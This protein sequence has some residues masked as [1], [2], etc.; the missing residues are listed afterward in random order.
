[1]RD[2]M[3]DLETLGTNPRSP[4]A[5]I[6]AVRFDPDTGELGDRFYQTVDIVGYQSTSA[7]MF[8]YS[9]LKW[10]MGL[11]SA[12]IKST[13]IDGVKPLDDVLSLFTA[14]IAGDKVNLWGN[15]SDFDNVIL[16]HAYDAMGRTKPWS[17]GRNRCYR[18]MKNLG[19]GAH[20]PVRKGL[21]HNALDD[22]VFQAQ[23]LINIFKALKS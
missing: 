15:G 4:I 2:V 19:A 11:N 1:M 20:L 3:V 14:Y 5:S 8:D 17:F 18:T 10:W 21:H 9:T 23:H 6:G 13:F 7:F 16:G 22:A 12:V